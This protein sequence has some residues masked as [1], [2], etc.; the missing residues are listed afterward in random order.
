MYANGFNFWLTKHGRKRFLQRVKKNATDV[1]ILSTAIKG[2]E[3]YAFVWAPDKNY[4][5][6]GRRLVTVLINSNK[7]EQC[8][9]T[10]F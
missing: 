10:S 4:P 6:F 5:A 3:G 2:L 9:G 8:I 1:E 7:E